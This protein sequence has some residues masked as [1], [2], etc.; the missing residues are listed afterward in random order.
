MAEEVTGGAAQTASPAKG[1]R[2]GRNKTRGGRAPAKSKAKVAKVT[3]AASTAKQGAG[4][5]RRQKVYDFIK[6]QAVHERMTELKSHFTQ[7][8]RAMKPALNELADRTLAKL[9]NDPKSHERVPEAESVHGFLDQ[10]LKDTLEAA[11]IELKIRTDNA[12]KMFEL[13]TRLTREEC[14]V[15]ATH[16]AMTPP[17]FS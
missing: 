12:I 7:L 2:G 8:A 6:A 14:T 15:S 5:G 10:R 16:H 3:K 13:N 9:T 11:D 4:R 17:C 1:G